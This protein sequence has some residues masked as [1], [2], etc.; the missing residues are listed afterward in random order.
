MASSTRNTKRVRARSKVLAIHHPFPTL[1][2]RASIQKGNHKDR[3]EKKE[4]E[5]CANQGTPFAS[6]QSHRQCRVRSRHPFSKRG[7]ARLHLAL[8]LFPKMTLTIL[9]ICLISVLVKTFIVCVSLTKTVSR[10]TLSKIQSSQTASAT[11]QTKMETIRAL[12]G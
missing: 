5:M 10:R 2:P 7:H 11:M 3:A 6:M 12:Q 8:S 4:P 9:T 1:E